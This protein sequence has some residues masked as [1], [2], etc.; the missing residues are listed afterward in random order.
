MLKSNCLFVGGG[1]GNQFQRWW[2]YWKIFTLLE[3]VTYGCTDGFVTLFVE[4]QVI[5]RFAFS[6]QFLV[7]F[8]LLP[9]QVCTPLGWTLC[10]L[11]WQ[12]ISQSIKH[13]IQHWNKITLKFLTVILGSFSP[14]KCVFSSK[15]IFT[16]HES[17]C[18]VGLLDVMAVLL[19]SAFR[20]RRLDGN[21]FQTLTIDQ[22]LL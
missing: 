14:C 9:F 11:L 6:N 3:Y 20:R 2:F 10:C 1:G 8:P 12:I 13:S 18:K 17:S 4:F 19:R 5:L 15:T 16:S 22:V 7:S 21:F